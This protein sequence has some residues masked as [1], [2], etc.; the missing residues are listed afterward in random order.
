MFIFA[1]ILS[2]VLKNISIA[3]SPKVNADNESKVSAPASPLSTPSN[4]STFCIKS[5]QIRNSLKCK[6]FIQ[7]QKRN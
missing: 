2:N 5:P 1:V 3:V 7:I 6:T 4:V